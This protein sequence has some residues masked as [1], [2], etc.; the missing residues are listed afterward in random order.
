M[1][2]APTW[3][4]AVRTAL[5]ICISSKRSALPVR[6]SP[7]SVLPIWRNNSRSRSMAV[8]SC[9]TTLPPFTSWN[10]APDMGFWI[11]KKSAPSKNGRFVAQRDAACREHPE[12]SW[13]PEKG[14]LAWPAKAICEEYLVLYECREWSMAQSADLEGVWGGLGRRERARLRADKAAAA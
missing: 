6:T 1:S 5:C 11:I 7:T 2:I 8:T 12:L 3:W 13:F 9:P 14:A 4:A 10:S